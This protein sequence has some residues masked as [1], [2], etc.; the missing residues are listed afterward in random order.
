MSRQ[1]DKGK[2]LHIRNKSQEKPQG[3][4]F[5][6][7]FKNDLNK[8]DLIRRFSGFM[9]REVPHLHLDFPLM[10]ILEKE[11]Q[12]KSLTGVQNLSPCNRKESDNRN[13]YHCTLEDKLAVVIASDTDILILM[14]HV[15]ASRI[16][17]HDWF[18]RFMIRSIMLVQSLCQ[19]CSSTA[20]LMQ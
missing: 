7:F 5:K 9:Q 1:A 15:L 3:N 11:A 17:D 19:Q 16:P 6:D 18:L 10:I 4:N 13:M 12:E 14:V 2:R 20:D 8:A